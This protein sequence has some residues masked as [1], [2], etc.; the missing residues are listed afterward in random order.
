MRPF[1]CIVK[2]HKHVLLYPDP[3]QTSGQ[4]VNR[5]NVTVWGVELDVTHRTLSRQADS[6]WLP[7]VAHLLDFGLKPVGMSVLNSST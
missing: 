5:M 6:G 2:Q 3:T 7:G 4:C 1:H